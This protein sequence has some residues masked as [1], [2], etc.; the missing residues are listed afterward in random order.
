MFINSTQF[1]PLN[2]HPSTIFP[3]LIF[4]H[5]IL[6]PLTVPYPI[7][8]SSKLLQLF[9]VPPLPLLILF[10]TPFSPLSSIYTSLELLPFLI[11]SSEG[12]LIR[13]ILALQTKHLVN[14]S[15]VFI[16]SSAQKLKHSMF[17]PSMQIR[18][19]KLFPTFLRMN[20]P[21]RLLLM[22]YSL[23]IL[24]IIQYSIF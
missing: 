18:L 19:D 5:G 24:F 10:H 14:I 13:I 16:H 11:Y 23:I 3:S 9:F 22:E 21:I 1:L 12:S 7:F 15:E 20:P 2:R 4:Y 8:F 6:L 17:L